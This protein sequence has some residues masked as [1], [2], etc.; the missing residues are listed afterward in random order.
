MFEDASSLADNAV[1]QA[2]LC[3]IG[4]G[5]AG[6][7]IASEFIE[8]TTRVLMLESGG[9]GFEPATQRLHRGVNQGLY[10][11]PLDLCRVRGFGGSASPQ[12]WGGWSKPLSEIDFEHRPWV[13][14]SGWPFPRSELDAFYRRAF[15]T[16]GLPS[17]TESLSR[18]SGSAAHLPFKGDF[19]E[20]ELCPL[21]PAP[22]LGEVARARIG[23]A[24]NVQVLL[25]A[26]ATEIATESTARRAIG[27][28]VVTLGGKKL[29]VAAPLIVLA[30]GGIENPRLLLLSN[31]VQ[32]EGLGNGSDFVGR[33][34]QEHP[35]FAW[36]KL[37]TP[38]LASTLVHYDPGHVVRK[39]GADENAS[40]DVLFGAGLAIKD[41]IQRS[42]KLLH[43]RSWI[44]PV[45]TCGEREGG[46]EVKELIFWL[47]KRRI[48]SDLAR[49]LSKII[50][51]LPNAAETVAFHFPG[52]SPASAAVAVHYG[53]GAGAQPK[54]SCHT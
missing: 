26:N 32:S 12:G 50:R 25:H 17:N 43:T 49:R 23:R 42:E 10:Y 46:L 45:P 30:A 48:P 31:Q 7:T 37:S 13:P 51:D 28:R 53:D 15:A 52:A 19:C 8:T 11:E 20:T 54:Q 1:L 6:I 18:A 5:A 34:F 36:G 38:S 44:V 33:C 22:Y 3:I 2:D 24:S 41:S 40:P 4:G 39:R 29:F 47:K 16:L 14:L 9:Q 27:V 35:R 21:S